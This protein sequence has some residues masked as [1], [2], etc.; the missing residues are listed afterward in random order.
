MSTEE[1]NITNYLDI[2]IHRNN[3]N[4]D[5]S[6]YEPTATDTT[7]QFSSNHPHEHKIAAFRYYI[8]RMITLPI[9]E[10]SKQ[11]EWEAIITIAKNNGY[12]IGI[13]NGLRTKLTAR[14]RQ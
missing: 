8:H 13:I 11:E 14:K 10:K 5:I 9:T 1:N 7:N 4:T 2:A 3:N 6:I 12:P